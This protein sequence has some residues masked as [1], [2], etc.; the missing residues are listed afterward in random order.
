[1]CFGFS[2]RVTSMSKCY[3][4]V[5]SIDEEAGATKELSTL[6]RIPGFVHRRAGVRKDILTFQDSLG[7]PTTSGRPRFHECIYQS[8]VQWLI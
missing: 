5:D 1:M 8:L 4:C 2:H 3:C 7:L 6:L